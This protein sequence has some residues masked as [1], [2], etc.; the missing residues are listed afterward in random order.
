MIEMSLIYTWTQGLKWH[1]IYMWTQ[2]LT[3]GTG[4]A[5]GGVRALW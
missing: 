3:T 2:R 4:W 1:L 5:T